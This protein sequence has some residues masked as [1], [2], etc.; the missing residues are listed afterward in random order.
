LKDHDL[1][2]RLQG[3]L[4]RGE[5][6]GPYTLQVQP[7][8]ACD[9]NCEFCRRQD[10]LESHYAEQSDIPHDRFLKMVGDALALGTRVVIVKG[11][12]EPLLR[13]RLMIE[14][15]ALVKA[16]GAYGNVV[17]NGTH[18]HAQVRAAFIETGWDDV[19]ISLDGPDAATHDRI[20][21]KPGTFERIMANVDALNAEKAAAGKTKPALTFHCVLTTLNWDKME[22]FVALAKDK[23]ARRLELDS[24]SPRYESARFLE[25]DAV[26]TEAFLGRLPSYI[27]A[28]EA[29]GLDHNFGDFKR[30]EIVQR[31]ADGLYARK[32]VPCYYPFYQASITP[33]GGIVP[34][35][36]AEETHTSKTNLRFVDFK[37]AWLEGD[38]RAYRDGMKTGAMMPFCKDCT[39]MYAENNAKL[40]GWLDEEKVHAR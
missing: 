2:G 33:A 14:L 26:S 25:M 11:G 22:A 39:F 32:G 17:T 21:T 37:T 30:A 40:R 7:T 3:W 29:A 35:C 24:L 1:V 16:A 19:S 27:K 4:D 5:Q 31:K 6:P 36:Y 20:R 18:L 15:A 10:Q 38:A 12:G 9:L 8:M 13:R 34:C 23:K 28:L